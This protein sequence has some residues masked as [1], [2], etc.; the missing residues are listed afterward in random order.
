MANLTAAEIAES[1]FLLVQENYG[2]KKFK[3]MDL[4]KEMG[5]KFGDEASRD[6]CKEAIKELVTSGRCVYTYFG[7]TFIEMPHK[8]GSAN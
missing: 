1:M 8:E 6:L 2:K 5:N 7:G 4:M 3:P